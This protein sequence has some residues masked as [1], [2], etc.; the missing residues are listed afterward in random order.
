MFNAFNHFIK[1]LTFGHDGSGIQNSLN[2]WNLFIFLTLIIIEIH[3]ITMG[4]LIG[5]A[6]TII[7]AA[8]FFKAFRL[9][10]GA[11]VI[12]I[13][14]YA[15]W[16]SLPLGLPEYL[17]ESETMISA[18]IATYA[19]FCCLSYTAQVSNNNP[20]SINHVDNAD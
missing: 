6:L 16:S 1:L 11:G 19:L 4:H 9:I 8:G 17:K 2:A 20:R 14:S 13:F 5:F 7:V 10:T 15:L 3:L 18:A 12:I